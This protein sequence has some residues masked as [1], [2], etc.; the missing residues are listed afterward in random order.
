MSEEKIVLHPAELRSILQDPPALMEALRAKG[1]VGGGFS[2]DGELHYR[3]GPRFAEWV[4][5]RAGAPAEVAPY[6]VSLLETTTDPV[7]L[8]ASNAQPPTCPA[9]QGPLLDW[10][11]QLLEWQTAT[12]P[13][14]WSCAKCGHKMEVQDVV[15]GNTGGM[16]RYSLDVWGVHAGDAVPSPELLGLLEAE[17]F[18]GW[19]YFYYRF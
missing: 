8:G 12:R 1:F 13:Y 9:C 7:F 5:F 6:H 4:T 18:V 16:A 3:A 10:K 15:W 11:K 19:R 2:H 17:T 14:R